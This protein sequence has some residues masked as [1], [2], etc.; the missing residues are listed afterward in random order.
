MAPLIAINIQAHTASK[1][2]GCFYYMIAVNAVSVLCWYLF[3][4]PPTFKMLY[5]HKT[6]WQIV[7][8]FD[9]VG[10]LLFTSGLLLLLMGMEWVS[11]FPKSTVACPC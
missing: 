5:K 7:K 6:P 2:R 3:Y 1:W 8:R 4:R 10:L 9:F 11:L